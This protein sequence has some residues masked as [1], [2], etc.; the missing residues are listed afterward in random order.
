MTTLNEIKK[1]VEI[2]KNRDSELIEKTLNLMPEAVSCAPTNLVFHFWINEEDEIEVNYF[3]CPKRVLLNEYCFYSIEKNSW[4]DVV[5]LGYRANKKRR[6]IN[7]KFCGFDY[8]IYRDIEEKI[9]ELEDY[10]H[11]I[12]N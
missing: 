12:E 10:I 2:L 8:N 9:S 3:Y 4:P 1:I 6:N 7:F 5:D 11:K